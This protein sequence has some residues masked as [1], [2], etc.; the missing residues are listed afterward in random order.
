MNGVF[1]TIQFV[2]SNQP[3]PDILFRGYSVEEIYK[4]C[5]K[6]GKNLPLS[7]YGNHKSCRY[8][9]NPW[10]KGCVKQYAV[11][12]KDRIKER[13]KKSH[14]EK[15]KSDTEYVL[16]NRS[17]AKDHYA[18]NKEDKLKYAKEYRDDPK[19]KDKNRKY[20]KEYSAKNKDKLSLYQKT[21]G[22]KN[23]KRLNEYYR[24]KKANDPI[25]KL[26][27]VISSNISEALR[28]QGGSK[29]GY[30]I[31]DK[32]PYTF[33]E[34]RVHLEKQFDSNMSWNNYGSYWTLD[35]IIPQ[36]AFSYTS[37][38]NQA[39]LDCWSLSNLQPLEK[40]KNLSKNSRYNGTDY[41][42]PRPITKSLN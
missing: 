33:E 23:R 4:I 26:R 12:N 28:K 11:D 38:D 32:L 41:K 13:N 1:A 27:K 29:Y 21:Y 14:E 30:S 2:R 8:G 20:Y 35:H 31:F 25:F 37:M 9:K 42:K 18:K 36:A 17:R 3:A 19:V 5:T 15:Q 39:F 40:T 10:C 16:K 24:N 7:A 6:C 34:L 22:S